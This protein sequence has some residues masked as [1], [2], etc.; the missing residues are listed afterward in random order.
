MQALY[1]L[2]KSSHDSNAV[3]LAELKS[4]HAVNSAAL[5]EN[6]RTLADTTRALNTLASRVD[7]VVQS[8]QA[9]STRVNAELTLMHA[10]V[11]RNT[12]ATE[13][14]LTHRSLEDPREI[15]VRGIPQAVT[16]EP[17]QIA[18]AL[19]T[20]L[21][22]P[23]LASLVTGFRPWNS[24]D[25]VAP[26]VRPATGA[27]PVQAPVDPLRAFVF[28]LAC[29]STR[30]DIL[31]KSPGLRNLDCQTIFGAGGGAKLTMNAIWPD[32]IHKLLKYAAARHKQLG[33]LR[34]IAN[35][36][37]LTVFMRP[38]RNGQLTPVTCEAD[39]DAL[40]TANSNVIANANANAISSANSN[41]NA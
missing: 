36:K 10:N 21:N 34:P 31:Q 38:T 5:A 16:L 14:S 35:S 13:E 25:R 19:L 24:P 11:S 2:I 9:L 27:P 41:V 3:S 32:P 33:Y 29:P 4:S 8:Q 30:D 1:N 40:V 22:L 37:N 26:A 7:E 28:T 20:A 18:A 12:F 17:L 23:Q 39:V 6:S 15:I